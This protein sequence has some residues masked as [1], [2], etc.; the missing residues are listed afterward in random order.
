MNK[1]ARARLALI[2]LGLTVLLTACDLDNVRET[3]ACSMIGAAH[4]NTDGTIF[5]CIENPNNGKGF[6][7]NTGK[8]A[9]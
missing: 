4:T 3:G 9:S 8:K 2:A 1:T 6:W 5:K 7:Y